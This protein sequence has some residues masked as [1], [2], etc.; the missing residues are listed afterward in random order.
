MSDLVD[1]QFPPIHRPWVTEYTD[2]NYWR[3]PL[4][5]HEFP[6]LSKERSP[7]SSRSES[8]SQGTLHRIRQ[9]SLGRA[10]S[11]SL[12]LPNDKST[13]GTA[14]LEKQEASANE[15]APK[16]PPSKSVDNTRR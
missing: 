16:F 8:P 1:Q 13:K 14:K 12:F 9:F 11:K 2:F 5:S 15:F 10:A 6:E 3:A 7:E 4:Q